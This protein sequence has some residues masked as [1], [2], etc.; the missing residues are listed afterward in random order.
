MAINTSNIAILPKTNPKTTKIK[1]KFK[2]KCIILLKEIYLLTR[3]RS[4]YY[5]YNTRLFSRKWSCS[6]PKKRLSTL[7]RAIPKQ[8]A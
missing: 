3:L 6:R 7:S 8:I 4:N 1:T 2:I 5:E